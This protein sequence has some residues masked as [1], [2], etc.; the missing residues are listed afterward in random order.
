MLKH[1]TIQ[2][3]EGWV[4]E[5]SHSGKIVW[6]AKFNL[7]DEGIAKE[8]VDYPGADSIDVTPGYEYLTLKTFCEGDGWYDPSNHFSQGDLDLFQQVIDEAPPAVTNEAGAL[9]ALHRGE[10]QLR[11]DFDGGMA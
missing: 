6:K 10:Y 11:F 7:S 5:P 9:L 2:S 8:F 3:F 4:Q 1:D